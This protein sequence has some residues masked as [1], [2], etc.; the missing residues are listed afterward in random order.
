MCYIWKI[1]LY[2]AETWTFQTVDQKFLESTEILCWM[3]MKKIIWTYR[4]V[5]EDVL[6]R[7]K[8]KR[9]ILHATK[10]RKPNRIGH[11]L[12]RYCL[13]ER[14]TEGKIEGRIKVTER[15]GR[16]RKQLLMTLRK[17]E[18]TIN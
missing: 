17:S 10:K 3:R 1:V 4:V 18:N 5:Y 15:R 8:E 11:I 16:R 2:D 13:L 9:H 12:R 7:I 14:V 6:L